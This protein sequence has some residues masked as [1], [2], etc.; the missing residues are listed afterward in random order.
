[1]LI[2]EAH[3]GKSPDEIKALLAGATLTIYSVARPYSADLPV[4]RSGELAVFIFA[5]PAFGPENGDLQTAIFVENPVAATSVGTPGFARATAPDGTAIADFSA[6]SG[7]REIKF[8]EVSCSQGA[9]VEIVAFAFME[10]G[11]WPE[12]PDYFTTKPRPGFP[13]PQTL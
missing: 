4:D 9:P 3:A 1:M 11:T 5:E 6:G 7:N 13:M 10:A 12:R 2:A 8:R